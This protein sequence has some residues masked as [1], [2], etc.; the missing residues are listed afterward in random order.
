MS[1]QL[2]SGASAATPTRPAVGRPWRRAITAWPA[3]AGIGYVAAW[4]A[5]LSIF[6]S[7]TTVNSAGTQV[8]AGY[9]GHQAV[10]TAQFALT[11]GLAAVCLALVAAAIG[12]AGVATGTGRARAATRVG[13]ARVVAVAGGAA[14]VISLAQ[15]AMGVYLLNWAVP[16]GHATTAGTLN[17][18]ITRIDGVKMLLLAG[19]GLAGARLARQGLLPR[20]LGYAGAGLAVAITVSGLGYLM[21]VNGLAAAAWA[22][23]PLLVVWVAG[24]GIALGRSAEASR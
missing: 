15:C 11:E 2:R 14:A 7:S 5:G 21:L 8:V 20:W 4:L 12:R 16:A 18:A 13:W 24:A 9:T 3:L 6:S 17:E 23:L 19:M 10:A 22:S 1:T